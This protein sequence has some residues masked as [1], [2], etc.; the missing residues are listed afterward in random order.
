MSLIFILHRPF[1]FSGYDAAIKPVI[2]AVSCTTRMRVRNLPSLQGLIP[3]GQ[4]VV[5]RPSASLTEFDWTADVAASTDIVFLMV[6]SLGRQGGASD[7]M[8]VAASS[9]ST[10]LNSLSP[11]ST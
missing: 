2:I 3:G 11:S 6:D 4:S 5:L 8:A 10:C 7:L 9:D 1:T